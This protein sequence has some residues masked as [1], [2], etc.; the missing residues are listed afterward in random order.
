MY[1]LGITSLDTQARRKNNRTR[2][3]VPQATPS[4]VLLHRS[5]PRMDLKKLARTGA[6]DRERPDPINFFPAILS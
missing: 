3:Q 6:D 1:A 5:Q 4:W 2:Q